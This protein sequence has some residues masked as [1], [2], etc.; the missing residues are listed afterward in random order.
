MARAVTRLTELGGGEVVVES[1]GVRAELALPDR[2]SPVGRAGRG[3]RRCEP[4]MR[5]SGGASRL[6]ARRPVS[7]HVVPG[8]VRDPE[9]QDHGPRPRRRRPLRAR[10]AAAPRREPS[11]E[12]YTERAIVVVGGRR[13]APNT[14]RVGARSRTASSPASEAAHHRRRTRPCDLGGGL[15]TP[16]LVNTHHHLYQTLT[17]TRAQEADLFTW[18]KTLYPVWAGIDAESEYAAARTGLAELAL[19]GCTTVFD[20]HYV[21]PRGR[22][23]LIEA[24][25]RAAR[26]LGVRIVASRGS[27]D[28]GESR[29]RTAARLARRGRRRGAR[30]HR[31]PAS[32]SSTR[33]APAHASRSCV[34][35][36]SPFSVTGRLMEESAALARRLGLRLHTHLAETVEEEAYCLELYGCRP[37][38]YLERLGWLDERRLVRPLRAPVGRRTSAAFG[39]A[40]VGVAHC[41]TSNLRLGA[42]VAPVRALLDAG[43][44]VGLGVDG[45]ASNERS[46][47]SLEVK[48]ALLVARGRGGPE[49]LTA[50]EALRLATRGGASGARPGRHRLAR[51]REVRRR[52]R[53]ALDGLELGGADDPVAALV[54]GGPHRVDRL[55]V[56]GDEVVRDGRLVR[57][58]EERDRAASTAAGAKIR[59][60]TPRSRPT[61]STPAPASRR[62]A[63]ASSSSASARRSSPT[64]TTNDDGRIARA[65]DGPRSGRVP[66]RLPP[67]LA[68]LPP[69]RARD[70][71]RG[72]GTT[73]SRSSSRPYSCASYRGS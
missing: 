22:D 40:G 27:M 10:A 58:D 2:R 50:R 20:H 4:R 46:D 52:R 53:L 7:D 29:G 55:Y 70:R 49:A 21:F 71:A 12:I 14:G 24:E 62:R 37:V 1:R 68:V 66:P 72:Q 13:R 15:V 11:G 67:A 6:H 39:T 65:R 25:V 61:C 36:C 57:A 51:A 30:G 35:P 59:G 60:V 18:L 48:Q 26:E 32:A 47:L 56:G 28:L 31:A 38:E 34:A 43:V 45:S 23:G 42:G 44:R 5:A 3:S 73:T 8:P 9:P 41:P 64:G 63:C 16:G 17:R 19:S 33:T 54:F 69:S